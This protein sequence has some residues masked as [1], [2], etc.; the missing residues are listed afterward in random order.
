MKESPDIRCLKGEQNLTGRARDFQ[1]RTVG[2]LVYPCL[3][4]CRDRLDR[5]GGVVKLGSNQ[6][7]PSPSSWV[8]VTGP[9]L[10]MDVAGSSTPVQMNSLWVWSLLMEVSHVEGCTLRLRRK[11]RTRASCRRGAR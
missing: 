1:E 5:S 10:V 3:I 4:E 7:W 6:I 9:Q 2:L 8:E 11:S